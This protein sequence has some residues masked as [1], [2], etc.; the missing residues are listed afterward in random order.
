MPVT[1]SLPVT[2]PRQSHH[3]TID[4][5]QDRVD[6]AVRH[7]LVLF[8]PD[9]QRPR[10]PYGSSAECKP[11]EGPFLGSPNGGAGSYPRP[12]LAPSFVRPRERLSTDGRLCRTDNRVATPR[13]RWQTPPMAFAQVLGIDVDEPLVEQWRGWFAPSVQPFRTDLLPPEVAAAVPASEAKPTPEW[14][15]TFFMYGGTWTWLREDE[16]DGLRPGLRRSLLAVRRRTTRPKSMPAW[17]SELASSGD[18]LM[19][20][21]IESGTVRPSQHH[22]VPNSVW[23]RAQA[24]LPAAEWL[25]GTFPT[26]GGTRANCFGT[27]LAATGLN[28]SDAL[29]RPD[30][31]QDWVNEHTV[32]ITGTKHDDEPGVVFAWTEHG[33]LAHA[34]VS[35]GGG[36]MLGKGSQAWSSPRF[37]RSVRN[38]VDSWRYPTTRLSRYRIVR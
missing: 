25:A 37:V 36:W 38:V 3:Q 7:R 15:D 22:D 34:T 10:R 8:P 6:K 9:T 19:Y 20:R 5:S 23:K 14:Q 18:E 30:M 1:R 33:Q 35:I 27:V 32:S 29:I 24:V 2:R 26:A 17:P 21:W 12:C 28:V 16:F 11:S 13:E 4:L 31:F